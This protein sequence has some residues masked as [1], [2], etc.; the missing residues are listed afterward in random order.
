MGL[1]LGGLIIG[2]IFESDLGGLFSGG[3][4]FFCCF[5]LGGGLIFGILRY[6]RFYH[7]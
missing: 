4:S 6:A 1:Y 7:S 5:F 2:W 3:L